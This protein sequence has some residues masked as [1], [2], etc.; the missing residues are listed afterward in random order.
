MNASLLAPFTADEVKAA[1]WIQS[2]VRY[3]NLQ[4]WQYLPQ[5]I[6]L[7]LKCWN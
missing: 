3:S 4:I 1:L 5:S 2:R 7:V 6:A